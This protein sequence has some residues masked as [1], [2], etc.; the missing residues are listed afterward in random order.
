MVEAVTEGIRVSVVSRYLPEQSD[1]AEQRYVFAYT[2]RIANEGAQP[3]K[4]RSRH[5][6]ILHG[7]GKREEVRGLGVVGEQPRIEP[8]AGFEYTSGCVLSTPHGTMEGTY[9][10]LRDDGEPLEVQIPAFSLAA[11]HALN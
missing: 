8:G 1:P 4:L 11:P 5:W 3:V 9:E 6:R 2:I 7:N 10:L